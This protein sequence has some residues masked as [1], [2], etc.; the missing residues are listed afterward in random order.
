MHALAERMSD[1]G[2]SLRSDFFQTRA[3]LAKDD[4]ALRGALDEDL[5]VDF[6]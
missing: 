1:L 5:L 4:R 6:D 3:A 2:T